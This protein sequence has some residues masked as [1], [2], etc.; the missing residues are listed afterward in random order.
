M[1]GGGETL[2]RA[3]LIAEVAV[4]QIRRAAELPA[5][6]AVDDHGDAGR[7]RH[8]R[9]RIERQALEQAE[10]RGVAADAEREHGDHR[11]ARSRRA[12]SAG[13]RRS[14]RPG[15][16]RRSIRR[17]RRA[18]RAAWL[19]W[20]AARCR[21]PSA[22]AAARCRGSS[23]S[24]MRSFVAID[25]WLRISAC[26][27]SSMSRRRAQPVPDAHGVQPFGC[28]GLSTPPIAATRSAHLLRSR[29]NCFLPAGVSR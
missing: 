1:F 11:D 9:Q 20:P 27:S 25:R 19:R 2:E 6:R 4:V 28:P 12:A 18:R 3:R 15:R 22:R 23:P 8:A 14:G 10:H 17:P 13:A 16:R 21:I 24:S 5:E 7:P 29:S 26:R